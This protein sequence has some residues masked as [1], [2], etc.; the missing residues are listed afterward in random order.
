MYSRITRTALVLASL[1]VLLASA[2]ASAGEPVALFDGKTLD[3][4]DVLTCEAVVEDGCILLK[5]GNGLVQAKKQYSDFVLEYEWKAL[6]PDNWDSGVYFRYTAVP[7]GQP[8]PP[9]YQV[10]LRKGMEGNLDSNKDAQNKVPAKVGQWNKFELTVKGNTAA[11]KVNGQPA[12]QVSGIEPASGYI[13]LQ[14]EIPGG[15]QF[16]F[17]N[18]R[19]TELSATR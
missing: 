3:G 12:W 2:A 8:W 18:I 11:L 19:I 9:H 10:N 15:G 14:A 4:W 13:S 17:R 16:L 7:K 6:K 5:A 1:V